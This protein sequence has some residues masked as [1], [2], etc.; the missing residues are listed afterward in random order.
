MSI[1]QKRWSSVGSGV[2]PTITR[3]TPTATNVLSSGVEPST[4]GTSWNSVRWNKP[5]TSYRASVASRFENNSA[6]NSTGYTP[7]RTS[8]FLTPAAKN[9]A[10]VA[11]IGPSNKNSSLS[12]SGVKMMKE[13]KAER[14][15]TIS[16]GD[17]WKK[18]SSSQ[19]LA[20]ISTM[21]E[22]PAA[23]NI[24][25]PE[26]KDTERR[27][28]LLWNAEKELKFLKVEKGCNLKKL[29][30]QLVS[31]YRKEKQRRKLAS[32]SAPDD[33]VEMFPYYEDMK[34]LDEIQNMRIPKPFVK[35]IFETRKNYLQCSGFDANSDATIGQHRKGPKTWTSEAE[36]RIGYLFQRLH[37]KFIKIAEDD[38]IVDINKS[39]KLCLQ[40]LE[41]AQNPNKQPEDHQQLFQT[42]RD[43]MQSLSG[44]Q[45]FDLTL[46]IANICT[47]YRQQGAKLSQSLRMWDRDVQSSSS[48]M[49]FI[50]FD[51]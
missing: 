32:G 5:S 9:A 44:S 15:I 26:Y 51:D 42:I 8:R 40:K 47:K 49:N 11:S 31:D 36:G 27:N 45:Q 10:D 18:L 43:T 23:W 35:I 13:E 3:S 14:K 20:I 41:N 29:F 7:Q 33:V 48:D 6:S 30:A 19:V 25:S 1:Y 34:F 50:N 16:A 39:I 46:E 21:Q 38:G 37:K 22:I 4:V 12:T 28:E 17:S 24:A 2:T